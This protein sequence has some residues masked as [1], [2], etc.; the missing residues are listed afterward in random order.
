MS[1]PAAYAPLSMS[2]IITELGYGGGLTNISLSGSETGLYGAI[3]TS[4]P[5]YPNGVSPFAISEW[6]SYEGLGCLNSTFV[7][8]LTSP[9]D[10]VNYG[11]TDEWT[12]TYKKNGSPANA[13]ANIHVTGSLTTHFGGGGSSTD[14]VY[15]T[16]SSGTQ[17]SN[18]LYYWDEC[19]GSVVGYTFNGITSATIYGNPINLC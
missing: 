13:P 17:T 15:L 6:Y 7:N 12:I 14:P 10:L 4:S 16:I 2:M 19:V 11:G 5:S 8:I 1:L 3:N 9:C 18:N